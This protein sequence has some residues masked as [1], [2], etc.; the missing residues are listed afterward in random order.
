MVIVC[1]VAMALLLVLQYYSNMYLAY[2]QMDFL[3]I[4]DSRVEFITQLIK[5]IR[6]IKCRLLEPLYALR[7]S[8]IRR[9]E[10]KSFSLYCDIK[11][12]LSAVYFNAGILISALVFLLVSK[13]SLELGK[14]FSTLALLGYIF[15]F[16]I[17]YSNYAIE[18]LYTMSVFNQRIENVLTGPLQWKQK[19][20][21]KRQALP[22]DDDS[23]IEFRNVT[24]TW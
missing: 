5:G 6:T 20:G 16:S 14:V 2:L 13:D 12:V 8:E 17:C 3:T 7:I 18:A 19:N 23:T 9:K 22:A 21:L 11:N 10:L 1:Y 4:A 15:N 24:T